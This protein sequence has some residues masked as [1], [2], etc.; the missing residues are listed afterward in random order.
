[1]T[2]KDPYYKITKFSAEPGTRVHNNMNDYQLYVH[3]GKTSKV[4][5]D[6]LQNLYCPTLKHGL[7]H[8]SY[9]DSFYADADDLPVL[10]D[11]GYHSGVIYQ[12]DYEVIFY[13]SHITVKAPLAKSGQSATGDF[14]L[15]DQYGNKCRV[16]V[17][18]N[19]ND[20]HDAV[21]LVSNVWMK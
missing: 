18:Y 6:R 13:A 20:D 12:N 14:H 16:Q 15:Q 5:W 21:P 1:M 19:I 3:T 7:G 2:F 9:N 8:K 4:M 11:C 10:W 17:A